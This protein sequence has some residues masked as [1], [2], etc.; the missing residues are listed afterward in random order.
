MDRFHVNDVLLDV[1]GGQWVQRREWV[2]DTHRAFDYHILARTNLVVTIR[3]AMEYPGYVQL[4]RIGPFG[5]G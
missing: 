2:P 1:A 4:A 3:L 5:S